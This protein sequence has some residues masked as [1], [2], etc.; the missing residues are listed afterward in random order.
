MLTKVQRLEIENQVLRESI[1]LVRK[2]RDRVDQAPLRKRYDGS[3]MSQL[4]GN[5]DCAV[6]Y[7][8]LLKRK[9]GDGGVSAKRKTP[10]EAKGPGKFK[11]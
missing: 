9:A 7:E 2:A 6:D 8:D 5:I 11:K 3:M 4:L 1:E 10:A